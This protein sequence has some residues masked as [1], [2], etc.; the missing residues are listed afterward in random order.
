M[1]RDYPINIL[2]VDDHPENLLAIEAVLEGEPYQLI[3]AYSGL[4]ALRCLLKDE[5]AVILL[6]VQMPG[7]DGFETARHI[8]SYDNSKSIPIIFITATS[9]ETRHFSAGYSVGAIDYMVKPFVPYVLKSKIQGFVH[10]YDAQKT[11]K[12]KT[13][14]LEQTNLDLV[15]ITEQLTR[16]EAQTRVV[17]E[18]SIDTMLIFTPKGVILQTNPAVEE[19]F[20]YG[21]DELLG[22]NITIL[23]PTLGSTDDIRY[24]DWIGKVREISPRCKNGTTFPAE[25][26]LGVSGENSYLLACTIRNISN[27]KQGERDLIRAKD[28]AEEASRVKTD[29]LSLM[30]HEIRTPL[31]G[32]IGMMDI[33]LDSGLTQEQQELAQVVMNSG[34]T[35]LSIM[36][37][38]LD[39]SKMESERLELEEESF[40]LIDCLEQVRDIFTAKLQEKQLEM[41]YVID[42]EL[43]IMIRGDI[44]RL[45]QILLNLIGNAIKFTD[46]GGVYIVVSK[47]GEAQDTVSIEFTI[48]DTGIGIPPDKTEKLFQPFSQVDAS[49]NRKYGGTGLGLAICKTLVEIMGGTI[50]IDSMKEAG[51]TFVFTVDMKRCSDSEAELDPIGRDWLKT[52]PSSEVTA[53]SMQILVIEEQPVYQKLLVHMLEGLGH[54]VMAVSDEMG[55]LR[56][57]EEGFFDMLFIDSHQP[58]TNVRETLYTMINQSVDVQRL[59]LIGM[60]THMTQ[61]FEELEQTNLK[62][63]ELLQKPIRLGHLKHILSTYASTME[64]HLLA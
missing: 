5:I 22:Q 2:L 42:R 54:T 34:N 51:A 49:V 38:V 23:L 61:D 58:M 3:R 16:A 24:L 4:D 59:I 19:M 25:I 32:V 62:F 29:F 40:L 39:F 11:L 26:Q 33:L 64:P 43:P 57:L 7:M 13:K 55:A 48:K 41:L 12:Q 28:I 27:R 35:L 6:D 30:S 53:I 10:L 8:K 1:E 63:N 36:N 31:N 47:V 37:N 18:T 45:Q 60:L 52:C 21:R 15:K 50:R 14:Q 20:G 9:K 46:V 44:T 56:A 17:M